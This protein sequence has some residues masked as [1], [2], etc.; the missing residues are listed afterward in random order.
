MATS[1]RK[2]L[3]LLVLTTVVLLLTTLTPPATFG[4]E[5]MALP[6]SRRMVRRGAEF[7]VLLATV[8]ADSQKR[9][10]KPPKGVDC[11]GL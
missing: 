4:A 1:S 5:A 8:C 9:Q 11:T 7:Q 6:E 2:N 10:V 3:T